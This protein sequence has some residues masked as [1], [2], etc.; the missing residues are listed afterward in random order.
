[1]S[2]SR[3][4]VLSVIARLNLGG[5]A[6][7][8]IL[9]SGRRMDPDRYETLLVHGTL[10]RGEGSM[11]GLAEREGAA[12]EFVPELVRSVHPPRDLRALR[13]L[14]AIVRRFRPHVV[15]TH[16]AKAGFIGRLAALTVRP[17]PVIVH[18]YHGH[19]LEGYF[20]AF[21]SGAYRSLEQFLGRFSDCLVG[22]SQATVD[23]LLRLGVAPP[24]KFRVIPLGLDLTPFAQLAEEDGLQARRDL[25][26]T[27]GMTLLTYVGRIVAIKRL[28]TLLRGF[29]HATSH[30]SPLHLAIVGD[31][32]IRRDLESLASQ[33][34]ITRMVSFLG[35]RPD[36][37]QL[38]AATDIAVLSSANEGTPVSLIEAAAAGKP[39]V[40]SS[41]GGVPEVV[42]SQTG[43]LYPPGDEYALANAIIRLA[44]DSDLRRRLGD[45]AR[46]AALRRYSAERLVADVSGLYEE[47]INSDLPSGR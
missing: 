9:P 19:V 22:G 23:D 1:M 29:A 4:R 8:A 28:D 31:G 21:A 10:P 46:H 11:V 18:S 2:P 42:T 47:L 20:G 16:T 40:A 30:E 17:R 32:V 45:S 25:G 3:I 27:D 12:M 33:L 15:H 7:Q 34:G 6:P 13:R 39:A 35:H 41:V 24:D 5:A 43:I 44:A 14:G 38:L 26:I 36:L 37:P